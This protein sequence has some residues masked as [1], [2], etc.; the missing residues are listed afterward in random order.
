MSGGM[1]RRHFMQHVAGF[2]ALA[3]PSMQFLQGLRAAEQKLKKA[4]KSLIIFWMGGGPSHM[5]LWDLKPEAST[6]GDFKPIKTKVPGVEISEVL[7]TVAQ[8]M[9]KLTII[10]SLVTNEGSHE[11]GTVLMNT[12]RQPSPV[13]QY[14]AM[15]SVASA[16]LTPKDLPLPGFIGIGGTAQRI[17]PGFLGMMYAP[18]TVQN[19]GQPPANIKAPQGLGSSDLEQTE[20]IRRRQRLFYNVQQEFAQS[21]LPH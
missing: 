4:N 18:F 12:G 9:D 16:Q 7:P 17:G 21:V 2:S 11:R 20:R 1:N 15:G 19:A 5:D 10:R 3:V 14:P 8:Q 13:V 6:A